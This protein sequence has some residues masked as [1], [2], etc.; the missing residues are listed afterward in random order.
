MIIFNSIQKSASMALWHIEEPEIFF[1]EKIELSTLDLER[2]NKITH[3]EKR[4]EF[5]A[6][7]YAAQLVAPKE[8]TFQCRENDPPYTSEGSLSLSHTQN[9]AAAIYHP[10]QKVGIDLEYITR[11]T[12]K[13]LK[14]FLSK[15]ELAALSNSNQAI[16]Y[17]CAKEAVFK[18]GHEHGIH[19]AKQIHIQWISDNEGRGL[20]QKENSD[21]YFILQ[22]QQIGTLLMVTAILEPSETVS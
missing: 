21:E 2:L 16:A 13:I 18:A 11:D 6:G 10:T 15:N 5:L 22:K 20:L 9:F 7:R 17:W 8:V 19:F 14:R 4:L 1:T 3:P 12:S